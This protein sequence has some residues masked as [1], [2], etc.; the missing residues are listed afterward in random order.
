MCLCVF[1]QLTNS[2]ISRLFS[3]FS[4]HSLAFFL[5]VYYLRP[6]VIAYK[7]GFAVC[8]ILCMYV[9]RLEAIV[10]QH[11][12]IYFLSLSFFADLFVIL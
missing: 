8:I 9:I 1:P 11:K 7:L 3:S 4:K 6:I 5:V 2:P 10:E 12:L